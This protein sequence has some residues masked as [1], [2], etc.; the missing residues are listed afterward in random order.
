MHGRTPRA[1]SDAGWLLGLFTTLPRQLARR[2]SCAGGCKPEPRLAV[3]GTQSLACI[4]AQFPQLR[5]AKTVLGRKR[6]ALVDTPG[7]RLAVA[8]GRANLQDRDCLGA[9][10]YHL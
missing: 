3:I 4:P 8:V 2:H 1:G 5:C 6:A 10:R 7:I 9:S